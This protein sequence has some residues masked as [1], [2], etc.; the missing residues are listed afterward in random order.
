MLAKGLLI[1]GL[2]M[3][4]YLGFDLWRK[5]KVLPMRLK[6]LKAKYVRPE[7]VPYP[8]HN[9]YTVEKEQL[10]RKLFLDKRLSA[11]GQMSCASCH[12]PDY[13]FTEKLAKAVGDSGQVL[14]RRSPT[15]LNV[16]FGSSFFWD[17]RAKTIE[18][19]SLIPI[20]T[21][22][23]MNLPLPELIKKLKK[24]QEYQSLFMKAFPEEGITEATVAKAIATFERGFLAANSSFDKWIDGEESAISESAQRG[25]MI[26][27]DKA[28]CVTCHSGWNFTNGSF[29]D[30]GV[31]E[32]DLGRGKITQLEALN[33]A[34]KTPTLREISSRAPYMHNG[35]FASLEEVVDHYNKGG[36]FIRKTTQLFIQP[37]NLS[38]EEKK[39]LIEFLHTLKNEGR[40]IA[41][42]SE[43]KR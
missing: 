10:G 34:F 6:D 5:E 30:T 32:N 35:A 22:E 12:Q 14:P 8:S 15:L 25:F 28:K 31:S 16:A 20:Q 40:Q 29:A 24:D 18:E 21:K 42:Q 19:Q 36:T 41:S 1:A 3:L 37:L 2:M 33:H 13:F 17:G 38:Q 43:T 23:E 39:D 27:N 4:A 9:L 26:F 11:S 7:T